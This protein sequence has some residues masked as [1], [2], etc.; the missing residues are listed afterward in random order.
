MR[1]D[2]ARRQELHEAIQ[3][4]VESR[5]GG[6]SPARLRRARSGNFALITVLLLTW[7]CIAWLWI[8]RPAWLFAPPARVQYTPD[9]E[10]AALRFAIYLQ[11][12]RVEAHARRHGTLPESLAE[13]EPREDGVEMI[14]DSDGY[15][16]IGQ[17]GALQ[18]R[19][20]RR[21][22]A[23]S[24]LGNSLSRLQDARGPAGRSVQ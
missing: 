6:D 17:R 4:A 23:D 13:V 18:L 21:M 12:S 10:E 1:R 5:Q 22:D 8:A 3:A 7:A 20:H 14:R 15:E 19:L 9:Q 11:R 24:F 2:P 16:L